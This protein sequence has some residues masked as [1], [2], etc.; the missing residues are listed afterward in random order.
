VREHAAKLVEE[1][2]LPADGAED[3]LFELVR[4]LIGAGCLEID[5]FRLPTRVG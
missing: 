2:L 4:A 1:G 3:A 5:E